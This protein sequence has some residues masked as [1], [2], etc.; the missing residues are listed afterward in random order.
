[1][2]RKSTTLDHLIGAMLKLD[3]R[4]GERQNVVAFIQSCYNGRVREYDFDAALAALRGLNDEEH[5]A[6]IDYVLHS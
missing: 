5:H 3:G 1:M 4:P 2:N 6:L